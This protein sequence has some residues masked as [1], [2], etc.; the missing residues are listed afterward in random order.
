MIVP[1]LT[2]FIIFILVC[3]IINYS[4]RAKGFKGQISD[5]FDGKK[6]HNISSENWQKNVVKNSAEE[7][8]EQGLGFDFFFKL[9]FGHW[10]KRPLPS[11][12]A[13]PVA[14]VSGREIVVT[15]VNHS[16]VLIQTEGLNVLTD[17]VWS[18]R[19]SP[20]P[21]LGPKRYM[22]AGLAI[23][24]LPKIDLILLSHNHYDHMDIKSLQ[25]ISQRDQSK[26]FTTLGNKDYLEVRKIYGAEDM[27][28][29]ETKKFSDQL[30]VD[31]VPAQH[32][33]SRALT[34]RNKTLWA[35]FVLKTPHGDIYFAADTG[36]G[37][38]ADRIRQKY[39]DGFRL[40]F[41]PI[42]A[43]KPKR[44]MN[45]VHMSPDDA[46]SLY[47][48]L[49]VERAVA[50]HF[51]TFHLAL[52]GENEAVQILENIL[53]EPENSD[54]HFDVLWNGQSLKIN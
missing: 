15:F 30:S 47:R 36:Y 17:P 24:D 12:L 29:F 39:P 2:F 7:I 40:A 35:G 18:N 53:S 52:D 28:W 44:M 21:F 25:K 51:G 50:I 32:F 4:L 49:K 19:A 6:F 16:T 13:R 9:F 10:Q 48:D 33:S 38:F 54:I 5:H 8:L 1:M 43:F 27:D 31:C 23:S 46:V 42:G 26:I 41:L 45:E 37:P 11:G 20:F 3:L 22:P 14:Q 34:D